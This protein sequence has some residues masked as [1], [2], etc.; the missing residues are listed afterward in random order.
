MAGLTVTEKE[1]WKDRIAKRID[2]KIESLTASDPNLMER[3]ERA[4]RERALDSLGLLASQRQLEEIERQK[5]QF[6]RQTRQLQREMLARIRGVPA[7]TL[8][9]YLCYRN[10]NEVTAA[11]RRR[12]SIHE[13]ELLA[14]STVGQEIL[15]LRAEKENLLDT[16][17]LASSSIQL[18]DLWQKVS[19]LL[20]DRSTPLQRDALAIAPIDAT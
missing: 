5:E 16:V 9:E 20:G 4:A 10:D 17:W 13:D 3:V 7:E 6:D 18:K 12:Q 1:H 2:K 15:R 19:D 14:E 11:I 8:D